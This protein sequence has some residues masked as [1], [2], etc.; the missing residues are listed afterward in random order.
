MVE[1]VSQSSSGRKYRI[2]SIG[3]KSEIKPKDICVYTV[4]SEICFP[5]RV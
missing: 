1:E 2:A 4:H 5:P 3:P